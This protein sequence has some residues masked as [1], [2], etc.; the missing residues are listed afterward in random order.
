[1][2]IS[3]PKCTKKFSVRDELI[4]PKGRLLQCGSCLNKWFYTKEVFFNK[5]KEIDLEL[6]NKTF[7]K[8]QKKQ[9]KKKQFVEKKKEMNNFEKVKKIEINYFNLFIVSIITLISLIIILDTFKNQIANYIPGIEFFL[10]NLYES[11]KDLNLFFKDLI[12]I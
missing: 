5:K 4:P 6:N 11:L 9:P 7:I 2:E 10:N 3:C 12:N 1:M 8:D